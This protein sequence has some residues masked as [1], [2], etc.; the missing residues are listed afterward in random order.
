MSISSSVPDVQQ[1]IE[2]IDAITRELEALRRQVMQSKGT[3]KPG[4]AARLFGAL[5]RGT[6]DEYDPNL[7]WLRFRA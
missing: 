1:V 5:G 6:W 3:V 4:L 2:R 7:D